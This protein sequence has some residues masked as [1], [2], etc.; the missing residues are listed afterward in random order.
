[1]RAVVF[2]FTVPLALANKMPL[3]VLMLSGDSDIK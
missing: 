3:I 1:M 2:S